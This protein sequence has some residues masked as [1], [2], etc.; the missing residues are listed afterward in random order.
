M[1]IVYFDKVYRRKLFSGRKRQRWG[2]GSDPSPIV[3]LGLSKWEK[4]SL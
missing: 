1:H 2:M 4:E 3:E